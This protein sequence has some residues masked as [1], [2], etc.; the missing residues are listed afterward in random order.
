MTGFRARIDYILKHNT[1]MQK[2]FLSSAS[3]ALKALGLFVRTDKKMILFSGQSRKFNDSPRYIYEYIKSHREFD[4]Y[5]CVW[6][7]EKTDSTEIEGC[8][9]V[10]A[11]TF[12]YFI[13]TLK[14]KYWVTCVNIE[15]GLRYKKRSTVY[16]NT[17]HGIPI[18]TIGNDAKGR[19]DYNFSH[20]DY[21]CVSGEYEKEIYQ[22]AFLLPSTHLIETGMPRNDSLYRTSQ[23]EI[24]EIKKRLGLPLDKKIIL[25]APTWRDSKDGGRSY[26]IKPP[27]NMSL[28]EEQLKNEYVFLLRTHPY[29]NKLMG[30]SF[31]DFVR[32]FS[33]YHSINDLMKVSDILVSDYSATIFDYSILER[34]IICFAYDYEEYKKERGLVMSLEDE[35]PGG[36]D[37]SERDVLKRIL[38]MDYD[39]ECELVKK[40]KNKYIVYGGS[41][42][43]KCVEALFKENVRK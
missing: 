33:G 43:K 40:F 17:W 21:F 31:N 35:M 38:N 30:V 26:E 13:T 41:A 22:R 15:R 1:F 9:I 19:K 3:L 32:D 28:W 27:I 20:I 5:K 24:E 42:T 2:V 25:Y 37:F 36:V 14:A 16:L 18:K 34:P 12:K 10:K 8:E 39:G 7:L 6:V 4:D 23:S 11:D 29:T